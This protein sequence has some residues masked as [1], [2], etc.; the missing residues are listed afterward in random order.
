[1]FLP[2]F[3]L[4]KVYSDNLY[5]LDL[6]CTNRLFKVNDSNLVREKFE[7][8]AVLLRLGLPSTLIRHRYG[9]F[10]QCFSNRRN[11]KLQLFVFMRKENILKTDQN[12]RKR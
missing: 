5:E 4:P 8:G 10:Q 1:M 12:F 6:E 7:N 11:L 9:A 3:A 2:E